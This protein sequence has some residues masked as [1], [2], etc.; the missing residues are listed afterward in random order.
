MVSTHYEKV[1]AADGG[2]FD[3][4]CAVPDAPDAPGVLIFQEIFGI[5][6]NIRGLAE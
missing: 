6:D 3:A 4:F 5:N 2:V 1:T